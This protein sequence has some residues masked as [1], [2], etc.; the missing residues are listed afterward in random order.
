MFKERFS[1][2]SI[3]DLPPMRVACFRAISRTPEDDALKVLT[4]WAAGAGMR[5]TPRSFGFDVPVS[6]EQADAGLRGYELWFVVP[7][8]VVAAPP[9]DIRD[10]PGGRFAAM[11]VRDAFAD[12]FA[13]IPA[14]WGALHEWVITRGYEEPGEM[15]CLEEVVAG[16]G[17]QDIVLYHPV[18]KR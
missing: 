9:V 18:R 12:P 17:Q 3:I 5:E 13:Y 6:P 1:Q 10:F 14:G 16:G 8:R 2:V 4:Q 7:E 11:T 15:L